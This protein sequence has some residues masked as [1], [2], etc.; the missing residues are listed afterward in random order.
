MY[1]ASVKALYTVG[2][3]TSLVS[4]TTAMV[5]LCRFRSVKALLSLNHILYIAETGEIA[6][7]LNP[8]SASI[9]LQWKLHFIRPFGSRPIS[10]PPLPQSDADLILFAVAEVAMKCAPTPLESSL[11]SWCY[12]SW[13]CECR[14]NCEQFTQ[15]NRVTR[16]DLTW[17]FPGVLT[18]S[19]TAPGT[20]STWT[21]SCRSSW[22]PSRSSLKMAC[23]MLRR[24]ATTV[25]STR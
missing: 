9:F 16:L 12:S 23:C 11:P 25:L 22:E 1:Y 2:Y 21:C 13:L 14:R 17:L 4:L 20:L 18:G 7:G 19:C 15:S 6:A 5:I 10:R 24:T 8:I 3:S